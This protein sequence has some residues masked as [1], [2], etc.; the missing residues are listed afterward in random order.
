[1]ETATGLTSK[2]IRKMINQLEEDKFIDVVSRN[3]AIEHKFM[4]EANKYRI[5]LDIIEDINNSNEFDYNEGDNYIDSFNNCMIEIFNNKEIK[6]LL[7]K[8]HYTEVMNYKDNTINNTPLVKSRE[9]EPQRLV[10]K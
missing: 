7:G 1:M 8:R 2:T 4:K 5:T 6:I 10:Y 9:Q 3:K